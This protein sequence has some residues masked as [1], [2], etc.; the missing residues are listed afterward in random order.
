MKA[1]SKGLP[2][3]FATFSFASG[4]TETRETRCVGR[5]GR[6]RRFR[7]SPMTCTSAS[8]TWTASHCTR[9]ALA[10]ERTQSVGVK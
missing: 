6:A 8:A 7:A 10:S 9:H 5:S 3:L 4:A 1:H 2:P